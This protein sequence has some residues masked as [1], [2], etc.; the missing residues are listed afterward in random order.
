MTLS[1]GACASGPTVEARVVVPAVSFPTFPDPAGLVE[2][3]EAEETVTMPLE[4]YARIY[5]YKVR[6]DEAQAVYERIGDL[7]IQK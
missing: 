5:E 2:L 7:Q 6:V 3:D 1:T 4:Y